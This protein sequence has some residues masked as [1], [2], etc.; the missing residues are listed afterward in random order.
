[1]SVIETQAGDPPLLDVRGLHMHFPVTEGVV[2][3][4]RVGEVR[5]VDGIESLSGCFDFV[6]C[7]S[8]LVRDDK[9]LQRVSF[10]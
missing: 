3:H 9:G 5:A 1:M 6:N 7:L 10:L 2:A 4:R 8:A